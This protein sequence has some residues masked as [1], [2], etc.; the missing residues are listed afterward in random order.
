MTTKSKTQTD[1]RS[2]TAPAPGPDC[3]G[4]EFI[5]VREFDAPRELVWKAC[6]DAQHLAQWWGPRGFSTP[7]CEWDARPGNKIYVVMRAPNGTDYAMGGQFHEV[8]PPEKLV[9]TTGAMDPEG[10]MLFEIRH[11]M[12]FTESK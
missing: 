9:T 11:T 8:E 1:T 5:I 12:A 7:V 10:R 2:S 3:L 6:T 4:Q